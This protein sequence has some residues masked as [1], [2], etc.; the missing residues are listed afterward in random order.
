MPAQP[1]SLSIDKFLKYQENV[2]SASPHTLRAYRLDLA[3]A[4]DHEKKTNWTEAKLKE[5]I[6]LAQMRWGRLGPATRNRKAATLKSF[7]GFLFDQGWI[8]SDMALLIHCPRVPRKIPHFISLDEVMAVLQSFI[9]DPNES[10]LLLFLLLYGS[11]L[12]VSEAC[13]LNWST[14]ELSSRVARVIGKGGQQ[15]VIVLQPSAIQILHRRRQQKTSEDMGSIWGGQDLPTRKAYDWIRNRGAKAGLL[16]PLHPHALRHSF[17]THMLSSGAN[18][19]TLQEL[20]GHKNLTATERYTH[21][22]TDHLARVLETH[23]PLG[24]GDLPNMKRLK[25]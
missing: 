5:W 1:L 22:G 14:L 10:E 18:L 20:L 24:S 12:R 8:E 11:G 17:A 19:R 3:Q 21:L 23:H 6:H 7:L 25:S 2:K 16:S 13:A 9:R 4:F 15:R